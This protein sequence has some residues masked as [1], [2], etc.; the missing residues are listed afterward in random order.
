MAAGGRWVLVGGKCARGRSSGPAGLDA[1]AVRERVL[2]ARCLVLGCL[3]ILR[4]SGGSC[5]GV[6]CAAAL[7]AT[8]PERTFMGER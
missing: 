5:R 4:K 1:E 7:A 6:Q 8:G 3:L 2:W